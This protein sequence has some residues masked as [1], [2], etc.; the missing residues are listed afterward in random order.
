MSAET[1]NQTPAAAP[2]LC[3]EAE[4]HVGEIRSLDIDHEERFLVTGSSDKTAR[5]WALPEGRLLQVLRHPTGAGNEG[6]IN[7][8]AMSPDGT[9]V[10]VA[11][12]MTGRGSGEVVH[13]FDR[14]TGRL[15]RQL[16]G[17]EEAIADLAFSPSGE[18]LAATSRGAFGLRVWTTQ[19]WVEVFADRDYGDASYSCA[20]GRGGRLATSCY[21]GFVRLYDPLTEGGF[22]LRQKIAV[23]GGG[24]PAQVAFSPDEER[25]AVGNEDL[26]MA[27]VLSAADLSL[28]FNADTS[29]MD[30][31]N[32]SSV[33]WSG[34]GRFLFAGGQYPAAGDS[35]IVRWAN[36]GKGQ[37]TTHTASK[38]SILDLVPWGEA[39]VLFA[40][41][42]PRFGGFDGNGEKRLDRGPETADLRS[43]RGNAFTVSHD[44]RSVR[45]GLEFGEERPVRFDL[46]RRQTTADAP[47]DAELTPPR[48][49]AKKFKVEDWAD[50]NE[51]RL[52]GEPLALDTY[53][54]SR[55]L[56]IAPTEKHFLLGTEWS[57][58]YFD[59]KGTQAWQQDV[60]SV[61]WG[62]NIP[63]RGRLALA[64]YGDGTVRWHR[65]EDGKELLALFVHPDARRWIVWTPE[66]YYDAAAGAD[67][68]I[69]WH[70]NR[71]SDQAADFFPVSQFRQRFYRPDVVSRVLDTLDVAQAVRQADDAAGRPAKP[72]AEPM[73]KSL[74]PPAMEM[75]APHDGAPFDRSELTMT[76]LLRNVASG[77][78]EVSALVDGRPE[79]ISPRSVARTDE[80]EVCQVTLQLPPADTNLALVARSGDLE[81]RSGTIRLRWV[82]EAVEPK[83]TLYL[84]A[85]GVSLYKRYKPLTYADRDAKD[86]AE[87]MRRQAGLLYEKVEVRTLPNEE[88]TRDGIMDGLDWLMRAPTKRDIAMV[89]LSGHGLSDE[90]RRYYFLPYDFDLLKKLATGVKQTDLTDALREIP[91]KKVLFFVDSCH[92]AGAGDTGFKGGEQADI[93]GLVN[94]LKSA[95]AGV[96]VFAS[97]TGTQVSQENKAWENGAFTEALLEGLA[98]KADPYGKKAI[99]V[100]G[101]D[102]YLANRVKELTGGAQ[103]PTT[104][105][106]DATPD[107]P[108]AAIT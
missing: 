70:V 1:V 60:P 72:A 108:I 19:D 98:G 83:P 4:Q 85:V 38:N 44:G 12:W 93:D 56:A 46:D 6:K 7:A 64:A 54:R 53:E 36:A 97:S 32:L 96:V 68:Q 74:M 20:F 90:R 55:C 57:L 58:R 95:E 103:T 25:V 106:P 66:G 87:A 40:A 63:S 52:N 18:Q 65:L 45:F 47:P 91:A 100:K 41:G 39:G 51:V 88:A 82:G 9:T 33:A 21:D 99:T 31:G 76:Y 86:F 43:K 50:T 78:A 84:L 69:G 101:L 8:V 71:G 5:I 15:L 61:V 13:L 35:E 23:P 67:G 26:T 48:I 75:L 16:G 49:E 29:E 102:F 17:L 30:T 77:I 14:E 81:G 92:A 2:V 3:I 89:F 24:R 37:R 94:E 34:D 59:H 104:T 27:C 107:F 79:R 10:A 105:M 11:G 28:L 80:A 62:V 73:T 42:D 22:R